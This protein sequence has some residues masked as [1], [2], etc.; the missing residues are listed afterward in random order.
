MKK[1][2]KKR[3]VLLKKEIIINNVIKGYMLNLSEGG[4]YI[5]T[6]AEF[7]PH[8]LL[9]LSFTINSEKITAKGIVQ[10]TKPGIGIG[11]RFH[12]ISQDHFMCIKQFLECQPDVIS[13][14]SNVKRILIV[15]ENHQSRSIYR[16]RLLGEGFDA[17]E[18]A[19]GTE[20]L[21]KLQEIHFDLVIIDLWME[22]IDGFKILQLMKI[23]PV[24]AKTPVMILSA[25]STPSDFEKA[26]ALGAKDYLVKM[27]T[28]P[29][30][31]AEKVKKI[32]GV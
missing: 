29:I 28:T 9:D 23:N 19:N 25:R 6:Q 10:H 11:V 21:K 18:A 15:D 30:K 24:L 8:V 31:L 12:K 5:Y 2:R 32:L 17:V 27:T 20:A 13:E 22:G 26:V 1:G 4:I 7:I 16:N 14:E 3:R